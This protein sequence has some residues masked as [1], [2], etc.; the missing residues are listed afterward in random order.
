VGS[1]IPGA[2]STKQARED[3]EGRR[4]SGSLFWKP[5]LLQILWDWIPCM[6]GSPP[7]P[8]SRTGT[9]GPKGKVVWGSPGRGKVVK[10]LLLA[11]IVFHGARNIPGWFGKHG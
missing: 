8:P 1:P 9:Y 2:D 4:P 5:P 10:E 3:S 11:L 6:R 7:T